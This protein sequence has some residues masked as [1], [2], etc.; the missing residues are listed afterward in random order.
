MPS[1][2]KATE[3]YS[4]TI[5]KAV[6]VIGGTGLLVVLIDI[7]EE[8]QL[9]L[10]WVPVIVIGCL[11][12]SAELEIQQFTEHVAETYSINELEEWADLAIERFE[13]VATPDSALASI[14]EADWLEQFGTATIQSV[15]FDQMGNPMSVDVIWL[16]GRLIQGVSVYRTATTLRNSTEITNAHERVVLGDR[17]LVWHEYLE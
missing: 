1:A 3:E 9:L 15:S 13:N 16:S 12:P 14:A 4:P 17:I 11:I 2:T 10:L 6:A 7:W 5:G 8:L